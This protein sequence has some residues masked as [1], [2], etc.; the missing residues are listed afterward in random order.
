MDRVKEDPF[1]TT[2]LYPVDNAEKAW[3]LKRQDQQIAEL[4]EKLIASQ[5]K[6]D[7]LKDM[8][9][10]QNEAEITDMR[11]RI[12]SL[13]DEIGRREKALSEKAQEYA[14]LEQRLRDTEQRLELIEGIMEEKDS[15]ISDLE[16]QLNG[17]LVDLE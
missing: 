17:V 14:F 13:E 6:I 1:E 10:Q 2:G 15:E 3:I 9:E 8:G 7:L 12:R 4:K 11:E 5:R 16:E